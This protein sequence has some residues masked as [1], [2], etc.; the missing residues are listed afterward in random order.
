MHLRLFSM[1][2]SSLFLPILIC[3]AVY[4]AAAQTLPRLVH[5]RDAAVPL[6]FPQRLSF[7]WSGH[8]LLDRLDDHTSA[9]QLVIVS[10]D[11]K[12]ERISFDIA[13]ASMVNV[14]SYA[15][16]AD[17]AI[18]LCG[19]ADTPGPKGTT[20]VSWI[21]PD[22]KRRILTRVWPYVPEKVAIA[23][24]GTIWAAGFLHEE[25]GLG[26]AALNVI[27]HFDVSG[28]VLASFSARPRPVPNETSDLYDSYLLASRDRV[29]W[30]TKSNQYIE[31][32]LA[33]EELNRYD[34]PGGVDPVRDVC[35][36]GLS[37]RNGLSVC[38]NQKGVWRVLALNRGTRTWDAEL[39]EQE[40]YALLLGY[41]G[42][43][44]VMSPMP[45]T[46]Q[47]WVT[48]RYVRSGQ[49]GNLGK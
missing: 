39:P 9:P 3:A 11:Y 37:E 25:P 27:R 2:R 20:Y 34:G 17:G 32:S 47:A 41:D 30:F 33:G 49:N 8:L 4:P 40:G 19:S 5:E 6:P 13:E 38:V 28:R 45:R 29:G 16:G 31:Y 14:R 42:E 43:T 21:S 18:A 15:A 44:L 26:A 24:D 10:G 23:G 1:L 36:V 35:G 48:R 12:V 22:R 46:D 7:L